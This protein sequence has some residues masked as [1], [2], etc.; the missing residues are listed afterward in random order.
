MD[1]YE[2]PDC[3]DGV[4]WIWIYFGECVYTPCQVAGALIGMSSIMFWL[5][6][7]APQLYMNFQNGNADSLAVLFLIEWLVGDTLNLVGAVL[8]H[9]LPT[10][11]YTAV[12]FCM[13]DC[14]LVAQFTYYKIFNRQ[15][16]SS[17]SSRS[18]L[19]LS[20]GNRRHRRRSMSDSEIYED[21][22]MHGK[23]HVVMEIHLDDEEDGERINSLCS[24][25]KKKSAAYSKGNS[26][27]AMHSS[28]A[29]LCLVVVAAVGG[30]GLLGM[31]SQGGG[32]EGMING[33]HGS[34][35]RVLLGNAE[36]GDYDDD[37]GV[38][39]KKVGGIFESQSEFVGYIIGIMSA[40]LYL[41]SRVP[42]I[43]KNY[44][45]KS[46]GGLSFL[47]FL[48]AVMGNFTYALGILMHS[49]DGVFI[50]KKLPWLVGSM[51]TLMFDFTIFVQ[52]WVYDATSIPLELRGEQDKEKSPLL[53]PSRES[54]GGYGGASHSPPPRRGQP[55]KIVGKRKKKKRAPI[56]PLMYPA[57]QKKN[58]YRGPAS[59]SSSPGS[60]RESPF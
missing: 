48:F 38:L 19:T 31:A 37:N 13:M 26:R 53:K 17:S 41:C 33:V 47:M 45:R 55:I 25:N 10:Q 35:G 59:P 2:D 23:P 49:L 3:L 5:F 32:V 43:V 51:G 6:A 58:Y 50:L 54:D 16:L 52:F 11:I 8:T 21:D 30:G 36:Q 9:Q 1:E 34:T 60:C 27:L 24:S 44:R 57:A 42:Q 29:L 14:A 56:S 18:G 39:G 22:E 15:S 28:G 40:V 20:G 7:Q 12:Y 46:T 4:D